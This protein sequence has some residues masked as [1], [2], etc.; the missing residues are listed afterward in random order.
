MKSISR[1]II[2]ISYESV[3]IIDAVHCLVYCL[4]LSTRANIDP[5]VLH[6]RVSDAILIRWISSHERIA[7][8]PSLFK[9]FNEHF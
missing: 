5:L 6:I 2:H 7:L 8:H 1:I 9:L 4:E 3:K